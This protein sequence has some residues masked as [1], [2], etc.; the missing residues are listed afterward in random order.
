MLHP[1]HAIQQYVNMRD[2]AN[3]HVEACTLKY[4]GAVMGD[5]VHDPETGL[6]YIPVTGLL[7]DI[8]MCKTHI[9]EDGRIEQ[10][11]GG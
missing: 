5:M 9:W 11:F 6:H 8:E 3:V 4:G 1:G 7:D 10:V 2:V